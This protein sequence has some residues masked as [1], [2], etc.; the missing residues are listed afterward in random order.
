MARTDVLCIRIVKIPRIAAPAAHRRGRN[1]P[2]LEIFVEFFTD[3]L[4]NRADAL[5]DGPDN[6]TRLA[7]VENGLRFL[8]K[9]RHRRRIGRVAP[10]RGRHPSSDY[11]GVSN[12]ATG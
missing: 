12:R 11:L 9:A 1:P 5:R 2:V 3:H 8:S 7:L 6:T 4:S 10:T